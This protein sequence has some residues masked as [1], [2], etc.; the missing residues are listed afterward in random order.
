[1]TESYF[2]EW[3]TRADGLRADFTQVLKIEF[4]F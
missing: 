2:T 1:I 4:W 3:G